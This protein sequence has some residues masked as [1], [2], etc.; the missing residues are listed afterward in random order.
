M[1]GDGSPQSVR[2][3]VLVIAALS[4]FIAFFGLSCDAAR[5]LGPEA[6]VL[7]INKTNNPWTASAKRLG[8]G[9][10][11]FTIYGPDHET[12]APHKAGGWSAVIFLSRDASFD[13]EDYTGRWD[14][15]IS[16]LR[17]DWMPDQTAAGWAISQEN[18]WDRGPDVRVRCRGSEGNHS[19]HFDVPV[20]ALGDDGRLLFDFVVYRNAVREADG[21]FVADVIY[22]HVNDDRQPGVLSVQ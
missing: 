19:V 16:A 22:R 2:F 4:A 18:R 14:Y 13:A 17:T 10:V 8:P 15:R 12:F 6:V 9:V 11:R 5:A 7:E 20:T 21:A 3:D 1:T